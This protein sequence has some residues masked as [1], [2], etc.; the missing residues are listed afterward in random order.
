ML[1]LLADIWSRLVPVLRDRVGEAAHSA[2]LDGLRPLA[3]ERGVCYFEAP[4]RLVCERV[5][6]LYQPLLEDALSEEIGT[7]VGVHVL[8][9]PESLL[10]G[11]LE[12]GPMQ[13][14][15]DA[16]NRTAA[17]ML[18]ALLE[19]RTLPGSLFLMHGGA[20]VGKTFL[21]RWWMDRL[22]QRPK[23]FAA[24]EVTKVYQACFREQRHA[25]FTAELAGAPVLVLDEIHRVGGQV[26]VQ[27]ELVKVL[28]ERRAQQRTTVCA[29]RWHPREI[30]GVDP[31]LESVL[32]SG[33]VTALEF[34]SLEAR[35]RY[36]RALEGP[37]ARN[38][39]AGAV[40]TLARDVRGGYRDLRRAWLAQ[41]AGLSPEVT[42]RYLQLLQ[43]RAVFDRLVKRVC[44]RVGVTVA[45]VIGPCQVR[46]VS[47]ARQLVALLCVREG[48]SRAEVGRFLGGR[49][50]AAV[51]YSIKALE[52]RIAVSPSTR[53]QV[54]ELG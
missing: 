41:R 25:G 37:A 14:M 51:S 15:V 54:E 39:L 50:R 47:F 38:G 36:V 46:R 1:A 9:A 20:G 30:R 43:P 7:R 42:G 3:M 27:A 49:S 18:Q 53:H 32:L 6:R 11:E 22:T 10:P 45:D 44:E 12:V 17:L 28:L 13:P 23:A 34:P 19:Q 26:R 35:L 21:L 24:P 48:M 5:Q 2:W 4:S 33:F 52:R 29:S 40:E 16:G 8:P 31:V